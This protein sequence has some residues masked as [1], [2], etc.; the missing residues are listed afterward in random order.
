MLLPLLI[1]L[2]V[3]ARYGGAAGFLQPVMAQIW[4]VSLVLLLVLMLGLDVR[5]LISLFGTGALLATLLFIAIALVAGYLLGG[6]GADTKRVLALGT[7]Q[8]NL[9]AAFIVAT[10]NFA[11]QPNVLVYLAAA[12]LVGMVLVFPT[13]GEFGKRGERATEPG[14]APEPIEKPRD[15]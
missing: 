2:L 10:A 1:G 6:P 15:L 5:K 4:T 3:K 13:A 11:D 14:T 9:S 7:G 8:R 12:G